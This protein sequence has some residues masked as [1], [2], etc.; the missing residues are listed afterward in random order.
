MPK[1]KPKPKSGEGGNFGPSAKET[2]Q[3]K[4]NRAVSIA[5]QKREYW[6]K[7]RKAKAR[8]FKSNEYGSTATGW[9]KHGK[10]AAYKTKSNPSRRKRGAGGEYPAPYGAGRQSG[11]RRR[12]GASS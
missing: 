7:Q 9:A 3:T 8:K 5:S 12:K 2:K 1:S 4:G 11:T 10:T 6:E